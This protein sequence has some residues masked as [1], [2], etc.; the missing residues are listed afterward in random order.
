MKSSLHILLTGLC[1]LSAV[2]A[3]S[4]TILTPR[5][6]ED[7]NRRLT[8]QPEI[9]SEIAIPAGL[10][11]EESDALKFL[12]AYITTP[13]ALDYDSDFFIE[14]TR[15]ALQAAR[16]MPWGASVPDRE[17]RHFVLPVRVNN[18]NLDH[19]RKIFY[20]ELKPKVE[21]LSME[22]AILE[23]NHWCH[24]KVSYQPSDP[25]TSSPLATVGN[26]LGRCGEESTFTVAALRSVGIPARQVYTPRWAHTDDNHAWVEAWADGRWHFL[27]ACEPEAVLDLAWFNAPAARGVLMTTKVTGAYDGPEEQLEVT[28]VTTIINVTENYAPVDR[29]TV[30]IT[31]RSG[32]PVENASVRFSLYNLA[33]FYP[34]VE[35]KTD[36]RGCAQ[37]TSGLGTLV[38]WAS[39]GEWFNL[40]PLT[41]GD[42]LRM[43]LDKNASFTGS[44]AFDLV[45]P[46]PGGNLPQVSPEAAA[47]NDSR[48][49]YEDSVRLAYVNTFLS[50][51]HA[52]EISHS[53]GLDDSATALL[54]NSR[55]N[56]AVIETFLRQTSEALRP[57]A[58]SLLGA[59]AEKD[60]HDITPDVLDDHLN[61]T[62]GDE[63]SAL[64]VPYI[65]N[66]RIE[67]EMLRPY[68][69]TILSTLT[70]EQTATYTASPRRLEEDLRTSI[71]PDTLYNPAGFR[72]SA[73]ATLIRNT[74]DT[75]NRSI[76]FVA[77]C[78]SLGVP[79]RID[80]VSHTTQFADP[81]GRWQDVTFGPIQSSDTDAEAKSVLMIENKSDL[82]GRQPKYYSQFSISRIINGLPELMEFDEF[83]SVSSINERRQPLAPGQYIIVSGQRLADGSVLAHADIFQAEAGHTAEVPLTI[84]QDSTALQVIGSLNAELLYTPLTIAEGKAVAGTPR[85]ILST[86]GRGYYVLGV[87]A[88]GHE[89]SAHA[90]NDI[91]T[92]ADELAATGRTILL[93]F[94][95]ADAAARF[96]LQDY[97]QLPSNVVFGTDDGTIA[98]ALREGLELPD[99]ITADL[100]AIVVADSFNRIVLAHRGYTIHLGETLART[101]RSV[102]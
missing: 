58:V 42:T 96:R 49:A 83:E 11:P 60:L 91:A 55:G 67:F 31:D 51:A 90:L 26:A 6:G 81:E 61:F 69:K 57:R 101:L 16:E 12:Y 4:R 44:M 18:E 95:D 98:D 79:A 78:R 22:E 21:N 27:G 34:L 70:P 62:R 28:P 46:P 24:E 65:L 36:S 94:P 17:W 75:F 32:R 19:S 76:A 100:P 45:P 92:A 72:Q 30:F 73:T 1:L 97:G 14:N 25:R 9:A 56:H 88:P 13:D 68:K 20:E 77:I 63:T 29:S 35:K 47:A 37:F 80:P 33:E 50:P 52:A 82:K 38:A 74:A 15:L 64:F 84:R 71:I 48:K 86:T 87:I 8:S 41:A 10:T 54:V 59:L 93:L 40:A 89:P 102:E 53:L 23:V 99:A 43:T 66:P 2:T 85:S 7:Y 5:A 3:P 39:D